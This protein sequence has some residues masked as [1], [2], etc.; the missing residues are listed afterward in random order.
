MAIEKDYIQR[1]RNMKHYVSGSFKPEETL[2]KIF[3]YVA[4][5]SSEDDAQSG[6][7]TQVLYNT[8]H[9]KFGAVDS[10]GLK[11]I[12][13]RVLDAFYE[14]GFSE[15]DNIRKERVERDHITQ[16]RLGLQNE[17]ET[18]VA[19]VDLSPYDSKIGCFNHTVDIRK[20]KN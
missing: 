4:Q 13:K 5:N 1:A 14:E 16:I 11:G 7:I 6:V 10:N 12:A 8:N 15:C 20:M 2:E 19:F 17:K 3:T 18:Y 9:I